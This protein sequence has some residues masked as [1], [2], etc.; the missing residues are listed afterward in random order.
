[1]CMTSVDMSRLV[2]FFKR[3]T[4]YE[5][6]ISDWSSD[7]CSSDLL[8]AEKRAASRRFDFAANLPQCAACGLY[9]GQG[10]DDHLAL[11]IDAHGFAVVRRALKIDDQLIA[12][13]E[14]I[15]IA[16]LAGDRKST[17]LNSSH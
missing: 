16:D 6:R 10:A 13:A 12:D 8:G 11:A 3:K 4:A 7:V 14:H 17:R 9:R 1:M 2:F 5:M 15:A